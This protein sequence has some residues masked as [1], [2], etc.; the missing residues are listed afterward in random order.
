MSQTQDREITELKHKPMP[1]YATAFY[2]VL[3][4]TL[5]GLGYLYFTYMP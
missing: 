4:V 5:A 2:V 3:A 1:G